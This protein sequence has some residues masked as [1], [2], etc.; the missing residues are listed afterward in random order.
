MKWR[1]A[2]CREFERARLQYF[3]VIS[4]VDFS[5]L[6]DAC[7]VLFDVFLLFLNRFIRKISSKI[8]LV[9]DK[10]KYLAENMYKEA[11]IHPSAS[12]SVK[13]VELGIRCAPYL[14]LPTRL[15]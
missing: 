5:P 12:F 14:F 9:N 6:L 10:I 7:S 13:R 15:L 2:D 11:E 1:D 4:F 3:E 8:I